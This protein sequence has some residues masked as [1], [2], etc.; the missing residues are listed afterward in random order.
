MRS[1][2]KPK[3]EEAETVGKQNYEGGIQGEKGR[4][5]STGSSVKPVRSLSVLSHYSIS[6]T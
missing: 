3:F 6:N 2:D 1:Q 5:E 4:I